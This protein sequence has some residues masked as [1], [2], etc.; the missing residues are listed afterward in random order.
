[1]CGSLDEQNKM[2]AQYSPCA[3]A[4]RPNRDSLGHLGYGEKTGSDITIFREGFRG[5]CGCFEAVVLHET[6]HLFTQGKDGVTCWKGTD[7]H[8]DITRITKNCFLGCAQTPYPGKAP[9]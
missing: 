4:K 7:G 3:I 6:L 2:G 8:W 1:H 9:L 5:D